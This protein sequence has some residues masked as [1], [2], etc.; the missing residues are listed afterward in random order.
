MRNLITYDLALLSKLINR[1]NVAI[2][3][4]TKTIA[5]NEEI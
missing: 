4:L 3:P 2:V 5:T 1:Y